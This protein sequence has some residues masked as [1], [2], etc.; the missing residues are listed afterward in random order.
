MQST[1]RHNVMPLRAVAGPAIRP[2]HMATNVPTDL[3]RSFIAIVD[4]GSMARATGVILLTQSALS[5]QMKRL[6]DLLQQRLFQRSGRSL[7]LTAAGEELVSLGRRLLA[8]NDRIVASL[9]SEPEPEPLQLGLVQDFADTVLPGVLASFG[10][11]HPRCRLQV[12]VAGSAELLDRFE[13]SRLDVVMCVGRHGE[14][15]HGTSE[16]VADVPMR[17]IG[18][19]ALVD[20]EELPLVLL[21][22]PCAFRTALLESLDRAGRPWRIVLE[23]STLPGLRAALRAG[24]G[25]SCRTT[26][27]AVSEELPLLAPGSLPP[28]PRIDYVLLNRAPER[29]PALEIARLLTEAV[30]ARPAS[31]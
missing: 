22:P 20:A 8:L 6:E 10:A 24:I 3:L 31:A 17:W 15:R 12:R 27:Y 9:G 5:L 19:P 2:K 21:E 16:V 13:A 1:T 11:S 26:G 7:L 29:A 4:A 18:N 23:T 14:L 30:S 25:I 28:L